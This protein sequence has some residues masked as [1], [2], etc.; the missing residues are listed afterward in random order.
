MWCER[1]VAARRGG[2]S[3]RRSRPWAEPSAH[4]RCRVRSLL[5]CRSPGDDR[6]QR[7][8]T[9]CLITTG[10]VRMEVAV[11]PEVA[12]DRPR[13]RRTGCSRTTTWGHCPHTPGALKASCI[14]NAGSY[15][16]PRCACRERVPFVWVPPTGSESTIAASAVG[17]DIEPAPSIHRRS[18]RP[19]QRP[20]EGSRTMKLKTIAGAVRRTRLRLR[21]RRLRRRRTTP[22]RLRPIRRRPRAEAPAE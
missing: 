4:R 15:D 8:T 2:H 11:S 12:D 6:A 21:R 22:P 17:A 1:P 3:R 5:M 14:R 13:A 10:R 16:T 18:R 7:A 9:V 20:K 19:Q